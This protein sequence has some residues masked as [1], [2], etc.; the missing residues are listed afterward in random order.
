VHTKV[1]EQL[2]ARAEAVEQVEASGIKVLLAVVAG[3]Y[4]LGK[5]D[6]EAGGTR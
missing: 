1:G 6:A 5:A 4:A 3:E 2:A